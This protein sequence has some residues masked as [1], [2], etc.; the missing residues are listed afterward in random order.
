MFGPGEGVE[1]GI[2]GAQLAAQEFDLGA[3]ILF[4]LADGDFVDTLDVLLGL[5]ASAG[6]LAIA[7]GKHARG[8]IS[9]G[10]FVSMDKGRTDRQ[11]DGRTFARFLRHS[12]QALGVTT[13]RPRRRFEGAAAGRAADGALGVP[14]VV[15][16][17]E[18]AA[19]PCAPAVEAG[20]SVEGLRGGGGGGG[21]EGVAAVAVGVEVEAEFGCEELSAGL[22]VW[23]E[24]DGKSW[25][26]L[27]VFCCRDCCCCCSCGCGWGESSSMGSMLNARF[28]RRDVMGRVEMINKR[29]RVGRLG[30]G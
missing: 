21:A 27:C 24:G 10:L 30:D 5:A 25:C 20:V 16:E 2:V 6:H 4:G 13:P 11:T 17:E 8:E 12:V 1:N 18:S 7:L 26:F 28:P 15:E 14:T 22:L 9:G 3:K 23:G 29:A 19:W